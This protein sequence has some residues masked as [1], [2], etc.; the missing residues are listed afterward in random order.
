[1]NLSEQVCQL[2]LDGK[3]NEERVKESWE[4]FKKEYGKEWFGE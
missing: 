3:T 1:M 4:Q 2:Y